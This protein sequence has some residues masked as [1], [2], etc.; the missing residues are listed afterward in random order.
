MTTKITIADNK[1]WEIPAGKKREE[2]DK[3]KAK[4]IDS[5]INPLPL[6]RLSN[7]VQDDPNH[8]PWQQAYWRN[9]EELKW[10]QETEKNPWDS[11]PTDQLTSGTGEDERETMKNTAHSW[12]QGIIDSSNAEAGKVDKYDSSVDRWKGTNYHQRGHYFIFY[13]DGSRE[14]WLALYPGDREIG[15]NIIDRVLVDGHN[16]QVFILSFD[17]PVQRFVDIYTCVGCGAIGQGFTNLHGDYDF[18]IRLNPHSNNSDSWDTPP[19]KGKPFDYWAEELYVNDLL[20]DP[21][22]SLSSRKEPDNYRIMSKNHRHCLGNKDHPNDFHVWE[23]KVIQDLEKGTNIPSGKTFD[24]AYGYISQGGTIQWRL[25]RNPENEAKWVK[26]RIPYHMEKLWGKDEFSDLAERNTVQQMAMKMIID[27]LLQERPYVI[28]YLRN[29]YNVNNINEQLERELKSRFWYLITAKRS[30]YL[31]LETLIK[32]HLNGADIETIR[33]ETS[34]FSPFSTTPIQIPTLTEKSVIRM[35]W[36]QQVERF[37]REGKAKE[38]YAEHSNPT[39]TYK[40][41]ETNINSLYQQLFDKLGLNQRV[42]NIQQLEWVT[43]IVV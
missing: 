9:V 23:G 42:E 26:K 41:F 40:S 12:L 1:Y 24:K 5:G 28:E 25:A 8:G 30:A 7:T 27:E 17:K 16:H 20:H 11:F 15:E 32:R 35:I 29:S 10:W 18:D 14:H 31:V 4:L 39:M 38:F 34:V 36:N 37:I 33:K 13:E 22:F 21:N 19:H 3:I 43:Q 6:Y 2:I